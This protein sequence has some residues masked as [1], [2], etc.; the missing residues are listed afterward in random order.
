MR[1][2]VIRWLSSQPLA[3]LIVDEVEGLRGV[4]DLVAATV[5]ADVLTARLTMSLNPVCRPW[6]AYVL[7]TIGSGIT[8][9]D[10][11]HLLAGDWKA[12]RRTCLAR[13]IKQGWIA[14]DGGPE[15][16]DSRTWL[17]V[18]GF[19]NPFTRLTAVNLKLRDWR[20]GFWQA[21]HCSTYVDASYLV[22][23]V[24]AISEECLQSMQKGGLGLL[25]LQDSGVTEVVA[26]QPAPWVDTLT[27]RT[28]SERLIA[29]V[30]Y[31]ELSAR[32]A[33]SP[34]SPGVRVWNKMPVAETS[35]A[36]RTA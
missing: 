34:G 11:R 24:A 6:D 23:P 7:Q 14:H 21:K 27:K 26:P 18:D 12:W 13:L 36:R 19:D 30:R 35:S 28:V 3:D 33:G 15:N 5:M 16:D 9:E 22:L 10:L 1:E 17:A 31:P 8:Q 32:R 29:A 2:D 20:S 4:P 25:G